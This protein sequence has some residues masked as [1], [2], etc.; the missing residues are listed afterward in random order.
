MPS[1]NVQRLL[2]L[3]GVQRREAET[4]SVERRGS[5]AWVASSRR[6]DALN[7]LIMRSVLEPEARRDRAD[8]AT[9]DTSAAP[10]RRDATVLPSH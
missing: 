2:E 1:L 6:L 9:G 3:L 5:Q 4:R 10:P 8:G 7:R